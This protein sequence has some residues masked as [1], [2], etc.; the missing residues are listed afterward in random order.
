MGWDLEGHVSQQ[1]AID[2]LSLFVTRTGKFDGIWIDFDRKK[3]KK[4]G[5]RNSREII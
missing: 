4:E 1:E 3:E 2:I 5:R